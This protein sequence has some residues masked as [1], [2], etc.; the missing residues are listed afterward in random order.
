VGEVAAI[1][2]AAGKGTRMK[3]KLPKVLHQICGKSLVAHVIDS[4]RDTGIDDITVVVGHGREQVEDALGSK[5]K[6]VY[7]EQQLG[8]GH[9][10]LQARD[11]VDHSKRI[12]VVS[13]DTPLLSPVTLSALIK[14]QRESG[15]VISVLTAVL[16]DPTGYG[17]ILRDAGGGVLG[18]VEEKDAD[19]Q[20]KCIAEINSGTYCFSGRFL[21]EG[22]AKLQPNNS[23]NEY[24]LTDL[25]ALAVQAEL[26]VEGQVCSDSREIQGINSRLQLA[27]AAS[28]MNTLTLEGLMNEGVTIV[29]PA[30]TFIEPGVLVGR[31]SV[32]LPFTMLQGKTVIGADCSIGPQTRLIDCVIGDRVNVEN[33]VA[34]EAEIG[35]DCVV[36][37]FAYLRPETVLGS[38]VKVG[39]FVEIKK[40]FID[41]GSKVPHLSYVGDSTLGKN[42]NIGAGTITCNYDGFTKSTTEIGDGAFIGSNTNLVAP[43][44]VGAGAVV[45]AGSTITK[46]V[47]EK[48]LGVARGKQVNVEKWAGPSAKNKQ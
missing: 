18:I 34:K 29:D 42:V 6:F 26:R 12:L 43:V 8:T 13:G 32:I 14:R 5:V 45:A 10:V 22:L 33:S 21:F 1:I 17:R 36:G 38:C 16:N 2:M 39:D 41:Q 37:P 25:V 44:R 9:A 27:E 24:Y 28:I 30:S 23:Q 15:A 7:Q 48:S 35:D 11:A 40:S 46:D 4:L 31:D 47:P 19:E 3:S 20:Q